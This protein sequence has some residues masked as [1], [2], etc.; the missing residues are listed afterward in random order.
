MNRVLIPDIAITPTPPSNNDLI[1]LG[2]ETMGTTWR[3]LGFGASQMDVHRLRASVVSVLNYIVEQM[4]PWRP[5]S[6]LNEFNDAPAGA[7]VW[8]PAHIRAVIDCALNIARQSNGAFDP[9][10]GALT[11]LWGFGPLAPET[12]LPS[13][14]ALAAAK[15][16]CGWRNLERDGD[17]IRQPGGLRLDLNGIA[18]G[19]AVDEVA[20]CARAAGLISYLVEIGGE[21]TGVGVKPDGQ[22]WWVEVERPPGDTSAPILAALCNIAIATSGDYRRSAVVDGKHL[23]HTLAPAAG[24]P[25]SNGVASVTVLHSSCMYADAYAT[26]LQVL[27]PGDGMALAEREHLPAIMITRTAS[28]FEEHISSAAKRMLAA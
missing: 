15:H 21:L 22:P 18:K 28:S 12:A 11:D 16:A 13:D 25:I 9:T 2:G 26:A 6:D 24:A 23:S 14:A 20:N 1:E 5:E 4:S 17:R 8:L 3:V 10:L 7:W 27:G 19:Y